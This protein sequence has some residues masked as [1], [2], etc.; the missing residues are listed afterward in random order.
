MHPSISRTQ[1]TYSDQTGQTNECSGSTPTCTK[2]NEGTYQSDFGASQCT[3]CPGGQ[4]QSSSGASSCTLC[5]ANTYS[6]TAGAKVKSS[7]E[8][9]TS[10]QFSEPG[11]TL[12]AT[13][14]QTANS[15]PPSVTLSKL[16]KYTPMLFITHTTEDANVITFTHRSVSKFLA[17]G[18]TVAVTG[19]VGT[20]IQKAQNK[21]HTVVSATDTTFTAATLPSTADWGKTSA[22]GAARGISTYTASAVVSFTPSQ[23]NVPKT[24]G[25]LVQFPPNFDGFGADAATAQKVPLSVRANYQAKIGSTKAPGSIDFE[26]VDGLKVGEQVVY[27]TTAAI[28]LV[29]LVNGA[30]YT[31]DSVVTLAGTVVLKYQGGADGIG[32]VAFLNGKGSSSDTFT[33]TTVVTSNLIVTD[34]IGAGL[35]GPYSV[36]VGPNPGDT[37]SSADPLFN[38]STT[39]VLNLANIIVTPNPSTIGRVASGSTEG[40][41][42][43]WG[44]P[45]HP[46]KIVDQVKVYTL[47]ARGTP[48]STRYLERGIASVLPHT[49]TVLLHLDAHA[50]LESPAALA[51]SGLGIV[52]KRAVAVSILDKSAWPTQRYCTINGTDAT[53]TKSFKGA[54]TTTTATQVPAPGVNLE[55]A[56]LTCSV[57]LPSNVVVLLVATR[58]P[59]AVGAVSPSK[60]CLMA[61]VDG[62]ATVTTMYVGGLYQRKER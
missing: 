2:C 52:G 36:V 56:R 6:S 37:S 10:S 62:T 31:I 1:G 11:A 8:S 41:G 27:T 29:P 18:D 12:C 21:L 55:T 46:G 26:S 30:S 35:S 40:R 51:T 3:T 28:A 53:F 39:Y 33:H 50:Y 23:F 14:M 59:S 17:A 7:C 24:G 22:G 48:L 9:C 54:S 58:L 16:G 5:S 49:K 60:A 44:E 4:Y 38:I 34:L 32:V 42:R 43:V 13:S 25:V 61:G 15:L 19:I 47:G 57:D 20:S 45:T